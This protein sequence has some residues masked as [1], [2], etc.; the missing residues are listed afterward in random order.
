MGEYG[1]WLGEV[2]WE[3]GRADVRIGG[4]EGGDEVREGVV[5]RGDV[6]K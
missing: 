6:R 3:N 2:R 1:R 5:D 4:G